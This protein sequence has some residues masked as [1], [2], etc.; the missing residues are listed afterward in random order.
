MKND[1]LY[2]RNGEYVVR[3]S[4]YDGHGGPSFYRDIEWIFIPAHNDIGTLKNLIDCIELYEYEVSEKGMKVY[5][6]K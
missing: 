4:T 5:G 2:I 1:G 6:Y 3:Y